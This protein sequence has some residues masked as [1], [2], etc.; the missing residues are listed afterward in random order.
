MCIPM[1]KYN[2]VEVIIN[3]RRYTLCGYESDAYLQM[4][5]TYLNDKHIE[6]KNSDSY[7]RLEQE[8]KSI[9][10]QLNIADDYF[11]EKEKV[12]KMEEE[13]ERKT[14]DI[15]E[16]KHNNISLQSKLD[17]LQGELDR[18]KLENMEA[19]KKMVRLETELENARH[20]D[21]KKKR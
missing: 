10:V 12:Q 7:A 3:N 19:Q 2:D 16:L 15:F 18:I 20:H 4:V 13:L 11:K 21:Y 14:N 17:V 9:L 8:V 6:M 5:A 1:K